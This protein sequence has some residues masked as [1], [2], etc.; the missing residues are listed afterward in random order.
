MII[1][2]RI[3]AID[4]SI[5]MLGVTNVTFDNVLLFNSDL[6]LAVV[7]YLSKNAATYNSHNDY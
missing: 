5:R 4:G 7:L 3:R 2:S 1:T 6:F